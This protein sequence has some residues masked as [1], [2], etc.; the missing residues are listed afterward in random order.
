MD[1]DGLNLER[2]TDV[3]SMLNERQPSFSPDG[4]KIIYRSFFVNDQG[5]INR[6]SEIFIMNIDGT[7]PERITVNVS[8][9]FYLK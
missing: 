5:K 7:D 2:L 8:N 3:N 6:T 4:D 1:A 9:D